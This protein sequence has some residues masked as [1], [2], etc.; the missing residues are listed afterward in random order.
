VGCKEVE[1]CKIPTVAVLL[2]TTAWPGTASRSTKVLKLK[3]LKIE[4]RISTVTCT[5]TSLC[6]TDGALEDLLLYGLLILE[7]GLRSAITRV[8]VGASPFFP[9]LRTL[10]LVPLI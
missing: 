5:G 4:V 9:Q 8:L 7:T 2:T 6:G 10:S 1:A 3:S